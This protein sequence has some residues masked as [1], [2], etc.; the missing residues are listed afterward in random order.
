GISANEVSRVFAE[1]F[2]P[3]NVV[4]VLTLPSSADAPTEAALAGLGRAALDV[5]PDPPAPRAGPTASLGAP[6]GGGTVVEEQED[7]A[8]EVWSA[9]LANGVRLH[10]RRM[11]VRR[12]QATIAITLAGGVIQEG[13]DNRGITE[14][15]VHAWNRPAT[16]TLG[17]PR[18][19][20]LMSGKKVSVQ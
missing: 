3:R 5:R 19:R 10:H 4:V 11:T 1:D 18:I 7:A 15:A 8:T 9:W 12:N 2:D 16:S 13:G 17:S 14:A 6:P 20:E